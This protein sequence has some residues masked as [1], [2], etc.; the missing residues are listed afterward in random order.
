MLRKSHYILAGLVLVIVV[1][2]LSLPRETSAR[3][4][5]AVSSLFLPL[6]GLAS[7]APAATQRAGDAVVPRKLLQEE[8]N[9]HRKE[10]QELRLRA[11]EAQTLRNENDRL[12]AAVNWKPFVPGNYKLG[13]VIGRDPANWWQMVR[14]DLGSRDKVQVNCPVMTPQGLVGRIAAVGITHADVALIGDPNCR[15][16]ALVT[17]TRDHGVIMPS[18]SALDPSIVD[19]AY[20][21]KASNLQPGNR[22]ATSGVGGIFPKGIPIGEIVD[23]RSVGYGLY[24]EARVRLAVNVNQLE[25]VWVLLR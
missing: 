20:L 14:I 2:L 23:S 8:L 18:N 7:S 12:R 11:A 6:F 9:Q 22:V 13:R 15:V 17:E 3:L 21:A 1:V 24:T 10:N 19:L 16:A 5:V 25:E 4:K